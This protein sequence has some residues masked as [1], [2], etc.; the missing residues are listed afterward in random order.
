MD[1]DL[2]VALSLLPDEEDPYQDL[3]ETLYCK[4]VP[5]LAELCSKDPLEAKRINEYERDMQAFFPQG[6]PCVREIED[7]ISATACWPTEQLPFLVNYVFRTTQPFLDDNGTL[8]VIRHVLRLSGD[9]S[10]AGW[11]VMLTYGS[12][13]FLTRDDILGKKDHT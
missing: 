1:D 4:A 10:E 9:F 7:A 5:I 11:S 12:R 3:L 8:D 6:R 13:Y 2:P